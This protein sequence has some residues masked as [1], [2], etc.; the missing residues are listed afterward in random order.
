MWLF[1]LRFFFLPCFF[2]SI[3]CNRVFWA[4]RNTR[5]LKT[6]L[7]KSRKTFRSRQKKNHALTSLFFS[8]TAPLAKPTNPK[9][10]FL[11]FFF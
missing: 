2:C 5:S 7:K 10:S 1:Y 9:Y 11:D 8:F 6:R 3:Y 4:F